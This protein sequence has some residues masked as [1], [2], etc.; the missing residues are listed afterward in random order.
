MGLTY[1]ACLGPA[2]LCK[3]HA[4]LLWRRRSLDRWGW[5]QG[6]WPPEH[7]SSWLTERG[8]ANQQSSA[9]WE[10]R[11]MGKG[12]AGSRDFSKDVA[13]SQETGSFDLVQMP[14]KR[15]E[16]PVEAPESQANPICYDCLSELSPCEDFHLT[17][18][19]TT[20]RTWRWWGC[21]FQEPR[22]DPWKKVF[23]MVKSCASLFF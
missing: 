23:Q 8:A 12:S 13:R 9:M 7:H 11:G 14:W 2:G 19:M 3:T 6:R 5:S 20:D 10:L 1:S 16:I 17:S 22:S 15:T 18:V 4:A 21:F